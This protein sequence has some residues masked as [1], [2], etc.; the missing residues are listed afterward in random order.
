MSKSAVISFVRRR[1]QI[2]LRTFMVATT[3]IGAILGWW[4]LSAEHQHSAVRQI[5]GGGGEFRIVILAT[6]SI[7]D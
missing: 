4:M 5:Q 1:L 6:G 2:S 7:P 3:L